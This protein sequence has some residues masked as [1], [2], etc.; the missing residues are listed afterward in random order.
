MV[1][2]AQIESKSMFLIQCLFNVSYI[3]CFDRVVLLFLFDMIFGI[4]FEVLISPLCYFL[5]GLCKGR[6]VSSPCSNA[7]WNVLQHA[8][9]ELIFFKIIIL[10]P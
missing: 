9:G 3:F 7:I 6:N 5:L 1:K 8:F 4:V 10:S 2:M